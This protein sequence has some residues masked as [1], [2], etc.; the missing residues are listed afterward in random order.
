MKLTAEELARIIQENLDRIVVFSPPSLDAPAG[1]CLNGDSV[2]LTMSTFEEIEAAA[3]KIEKD[4][5]EVQ[6]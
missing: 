2:M 4:H 1:V 6:A 5:K 3:R